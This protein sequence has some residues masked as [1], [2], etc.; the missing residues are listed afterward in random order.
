MTHPRPI[1]R[2]ILR[3]AAIAAAL[4]GSTWLSGVRVF[5]FSGDS[6]IP[7]VHG[8]DRFVGLVGL[9][10]AREPKRFDQLIFEVPGTSRWAGQKIPWMKRLVGLPREQVRLA[11]ADLFINGRKIE[12]PYL[13]AD[14]PARTRKDFEITLG[15]DEYCVLGDNL[16]HTLEDSRVL[17]PIKRSL[18]RGVVAFVVP[19]NRN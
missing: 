1:R 12:A 7:A 16:D 4:L 17:G 9:W 13:H 8:G 10:N 11:G 3:L 6:M 19:G 15:D 2:K 5:A 18:V 14:S